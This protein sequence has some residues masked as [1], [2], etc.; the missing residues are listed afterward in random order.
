MALLLFAGK[1]THK[2]PVIPGAAVFLN[3]NIT[4][5]YPETGIAGLKMRIQHWERKVFSVA[6]TG[7]TPGGAAYKVVMM[8]VMPEGRPGSAVWTGDKLNHTIFNLDLPMLLIK[9]NLYLV[10]VPGRCNC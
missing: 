9:R 8:P 1:F 4:L 3:E 5:H 10:Q 6:K 7:K 2:F